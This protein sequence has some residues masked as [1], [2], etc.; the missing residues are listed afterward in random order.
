MLHFFNFCLP[1]AALSSQQDLQISAANYV[2]QP[3]G[4]NTTFGL[5]QHGST[6]SPLSLR[7]F[8]CLPLRACARVGPTALVWPVAG[9]HTCL[10]HLAGL[11]AVS[12]ILAHNAKMEHNFKLLCPQRN[13]RNSPA[14]TGP[15]CPEKG[16]TRLN[17]SQVC[18]TTA[19]AIRTLAGRKASKNA[20]QITKTCGGTDPP[21]RTLT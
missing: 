14:I 4:R 21:H 11:P 12:P 17:E 9:T 7:V 15:F 10:P 19:H 20:K 5:P 13:Q 2:P 18:L 1:E 3:T 8:C 16:T 6:C